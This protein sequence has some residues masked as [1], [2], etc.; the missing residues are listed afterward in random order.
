MHTKSNPQ[1]ETEFPLLQGLLNNGLFCPLDRV[2]T[3]PSNS[4][5][6]CNSD[7]NNHRTSLLDVFIAVLW[8][9]WLIS[10]AE[11]GQK[12]AGGRSRVCPNFY[13]RLLVTGMCTLILWIIRLVLH[14]NNMPPQ[15][16]KK[17]KCL[18]ILDF[19]LLTPGCRTKSLERNTNAAQVLLIHLIIIPIIIFTLRAC[20]VILQSFCGASDQNMLCRSANS[21]T[22][23]PQNQK[24]LRVG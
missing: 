10:P 12:R 24:C 3:S 1:L 6:H 9:L 19:Y 13:C 8:L 22:E 11:K 5:E 2:R 20:K 18:D 4:P 7:Q 23:W 17:L 14:R 15:H 21:A 16:V